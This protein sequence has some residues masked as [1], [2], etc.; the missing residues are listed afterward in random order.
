M[1]KNAFAKNCWYVAG[2]SDEFSSTKPVAKTL[3]GEGIVIYRKKS[4]DLVA[5]VD[6]CVHR[7]APLSMGRIE[8]DSIR[9]M[10]HGFSFNADGQC[11]EIPGQETI[12]KKACVNTY[13]IAEKGSWVWVWIGDKSK[14]DVDL[15]PPVS[16][17]DDP[18]WVLKTGMLD[19]DAPY[20]LINDN[21]L[22]LSHLA[23]VHAES[24][25]A[26]TGWSNKPPVTTTFDRGIKVDRWV[27][28][29]PPVPP[30]PSLAQYESVDLWVTY[31]F[32]VP[33]IFIMYTAMYPPGTA[34]S[35]NHEAPS[36]QRLFSNLSCQVITPLTENT[37]RTFFNWGPG[38]EFGNEEIAE[39]M[40]TIAT[41]AFREDK[42][43]I[44][45]Q[46]KVIA[47]D[48][49]LPMLPSASDKSVSLFRRIMDGFK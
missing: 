12:P 44:E 27:Q 48:P 20:E 17:L 34:I 43:I 37:S 41:M 10:Y 23:Y 11:I 7:H 32:Y 47:R 42:E 18:E 4:G 28:D 9:C 35:H 19:Y 22:D 30:L 5:L 1:E 8:G 21:L 29:A 14:A 16:G 33:G 25:G 6:R 31:K 2:W 26:T 36:G 45:A 39:Q 15:I 46:T 38:S 49:E 13:P 3:T 40:I 24:F